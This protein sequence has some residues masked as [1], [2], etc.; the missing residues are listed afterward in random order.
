M[1]T[2]AQRKQG[3]KIFGL[4]YHDKLMQFVSIAATVYS[5]TI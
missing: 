2:H 5:K 3:I 4:S 1:N